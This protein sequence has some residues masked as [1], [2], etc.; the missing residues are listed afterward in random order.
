MVVRAPNKQTTLLMSVTP[1]Q[2]MDV[3]YLGLMYLRNFKTNNSKIH[4]LLLSYST[5]FEL[6]VDSRLIRIEQC[7][8]GKWTLALLERILKNTFLRMLNQMNINLFH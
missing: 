5:G 4:G 7:H 2:D 1:I 8:L 6:S 3:G